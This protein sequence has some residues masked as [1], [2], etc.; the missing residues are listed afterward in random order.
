MF[1]AHALSAFRLVFEANCVD[2][3]SRLITIINSG[4]QS[5]QRQRAYGK[6]V[7]SR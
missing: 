1:L 2:T 5:R 4:Q 6:R 7:I 3:L